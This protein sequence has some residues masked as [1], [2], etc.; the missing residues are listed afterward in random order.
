MK[1]QLWTIVRFPDGSWSFGGKP[2]DPAYEFCEKW[3][4]AAVEAKHAVKL[5]QVRR[6][7]T[8]SKRLQAI[9]ETLCPDDILDAGDP[10]RPIIVEEM[11]LVM[12]APSDAEAVSTISWWNSWP[13]PQHLSAEGFVRAARELFR[14]VDDANNFR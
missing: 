10:R 9:Y 14:R 8:L 11:R 13:N 2:N 7:R 12:E 5:A 6:R 1:E 3:R 4:I